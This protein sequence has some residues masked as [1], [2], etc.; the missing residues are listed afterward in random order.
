MKFMLKPTASR[1]RRESGMAIIVT[2]I[3]LTFLIPMV[4]LAVDGGVMFIVRARLEAALDSAALAAGRGLNTG[5]TQG[6]SAQERRGTAAR[7]FGGRLVSP[8]LERTQ[9][10]QEVEPRGG[11]YVQG[12][13]FL[14]RQIHQIHQIHQIIGS[15]ARP[16]RPRRVR[17]V[18]PSH[19]VGTAGTGAC[20]GTRDYRS[21]V[22]SQRKSGQF[23]NRT[24]TGYPGRRPGERRWCLPR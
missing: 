17:E 7:P 14:F 4:G 21:A 24:Q 9:P 3:M 20:S 16:G 5:T 11:P 13:K 1:L 6:I 19:P 2:A 15:P 10:H 23:N 12:N 22:S 8:G 18:L